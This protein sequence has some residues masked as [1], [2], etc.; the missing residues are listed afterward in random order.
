MATNRQLMDQYIS[1][2]DHLF[3]GNL[4]DQYI[5]SIFV[6]QSYFI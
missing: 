2:I 1:V 6:K 5:G 3:M 4:M